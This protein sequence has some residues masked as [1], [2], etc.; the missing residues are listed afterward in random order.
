[1]SEPIDQT[2]ADRLVR[3]GEEKLT[4][5]HE[6]YARNPVGAAT[7]FRRGMVTEWRHLLHLLYG[8]RTTRELVLRARN[9][10]KLSVPHAG[11]LLDD[12]QSYLGIDSGCDMGPWGRID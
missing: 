9:N 8:E 5:F 7:E 12:G 1:M 4:A 3:H 2:L 11:P 6:E 10:V